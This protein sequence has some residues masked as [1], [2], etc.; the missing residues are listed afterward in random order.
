MT[1]Y[2]TFE[3]IKQERISLDTEL[4][5]SEKMHGERKIRMENLFLPSGSSIIPGTTYK[6]HC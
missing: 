1:I 6:S 5:V 3:A 2:L 4:V